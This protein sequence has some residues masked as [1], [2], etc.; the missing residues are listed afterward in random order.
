M[1]SNL[2]VLL[3]DEKDEAT[4]KLSFVLRNN[5]M[6]VRL[7][8]KNGAELLNKELDT[9]YERLSPI[10]E[11]ESWGFSGNDFLNCVVI[12]DSDIKPEDLLKICKKIER[13]L[14]RCDAPEYDASGAR[15]YHNR[16][17]DID[18][19]LYGEET[20]STQDLTIPH[21][22]MKNREFII[23][24]LNLLDFNKKINT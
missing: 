4:Q 2:S 21:P 14:G 9:Q 24:C 10:I 13:E 7:C 20:I 8:A 1:V 22:Q 23:K 18:I 5:K 17:M 11:T 15:I 6:D 19:L 3:T 16:T 12:Y